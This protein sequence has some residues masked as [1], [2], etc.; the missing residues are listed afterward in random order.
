MKRHMELSP[1]EL[2]KWVNRYGDELLRICYL[3]LF[4]VEMASNVVQTAFVEVYRA[5]KKP[6]ENTERLYLLHI[7]IKICKGAAHLVKKPDIKHI[8]KPVLRSITKMKPL[9]RV[10]I[11]LKY[12]ADLSEQDISQILYIPIVLI[13][14][15]LAI[16]ENELK[17]VEKWELDK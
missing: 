8:E 10:V 6:S 12:Y 5:G 15:L 13:K 17:K 2:E 9:C 1:D 14:L 7:T 16:G 3:I 4:D 11:I